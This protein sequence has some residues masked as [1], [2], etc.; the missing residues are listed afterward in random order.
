MQPDRPEDLATALRKLAGSQE[1]RLALAA[2]AAGTPGILSD[3][4]C[5]TAHAVFFQEFSSAA[6]STEKGRR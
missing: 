5:T 4:E 3:I 2:G 1:M 6:G